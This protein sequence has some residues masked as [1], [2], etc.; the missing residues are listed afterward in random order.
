MTVEEIYPVVYQWIGVHDQ[1]VINDLGKLESDLAKTQSWF[2]QVSQRLSNLGSGTNPVDPVLADLSTNIL[3]VQL[4]YLEIMMLKI[5]ERKLGIE[6]RKYE[7]AQ[8]FIEKH[9]RKCFRSKSS[10]VLR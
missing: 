10:S 1:G 8:Q 7:L 2:N 9:A 6:D 5:E 3:K 4:V